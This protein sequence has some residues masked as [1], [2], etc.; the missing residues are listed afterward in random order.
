[1][2]TALVE[3]RTVLQKGGVEG[4]QNCANLPHM[5]RVAHRKQLLSTYAEERRPVALQ[6]TVLS[7][8]NYK[9]VADIS[10]CSWPDFKPIEPPDISPACNA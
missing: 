8:R 3:A 7:L 5:S 6:N 1:M 4:Q 10:L 2:P 9:Y